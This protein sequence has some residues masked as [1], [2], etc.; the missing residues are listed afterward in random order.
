MKSLFGESLDLLRQVLDETENGYHIRSKTRMK[1][2]KHIE[3]CEET[4]KKFE[5]I[6]KDQ[7]SSYSG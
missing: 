6:Y 3:F 4:A 1:I 5:D 7:W 2:K